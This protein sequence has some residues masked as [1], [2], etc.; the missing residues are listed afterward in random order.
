MWNTHTHTHTPPTHTHR[1]KDKEVHIYRN[2]HLHGK[3]YSTVQ[4]RERGREKS[5]SR[6]KTDWQLASTHSIPPFF[7]KLCSAFAI[8]PPPVPPCPFRMQIHSWHSHGGHETVVWVRPVCTCVCVGAILFLHLRNNVK[9]L[10][11]TEADRGTSQAL[12]MLRDRCLSL[13]HLAFQLTLTSAA[14][15]ATLCNWQWGF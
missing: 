12:K 13:L 15:S 3:D 2:S 6:F 10:K 1:K 4:W 9:L 8:L 14:K 11:R 7:C 5:S